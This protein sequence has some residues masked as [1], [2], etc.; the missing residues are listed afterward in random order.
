MAPKPVTTTRFNSIFITFVR[1]I[2]F[3]TKSNS[4][5]VYNKLITKLIVK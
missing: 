4:S 5:I 1:L 2:V 3:N